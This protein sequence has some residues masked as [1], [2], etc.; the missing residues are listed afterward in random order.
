MSDATSRFEERAVELAVAFGGRMVKFIG[1]EVMFV[2]PD[3][4]GAVEV[5]RGL[6]AHVIG[7]PELRTARAGVAHGEMLGRDGDWFGTT[8]N[9]AARLVERAKGGEILCAGIGA[10]EIE[11]VT[12]R[13]RK[14]LR[15]LDDRIEI[16]RID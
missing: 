1:D 3:L 15:G 16:Y 5:A 2:A 8:V 13:T 9:I 12:S 7:D 6:L 11:G 4:A 10:D 14:R